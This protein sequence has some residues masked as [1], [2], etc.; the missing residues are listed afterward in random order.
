MDGIIMNQFQRYVIRTF[1]REAWTNLLEAANLPLSDE[2]L[3]VG[4]IYP[5][6]DLLALLTAAVDLTGRSLPDLLEDFGFYI[7][8]TLIR[9]YQALI[10]PGWG[11]L[12]LI[13]HTEQSIH[14]V[15]RQR[16]PGAAP[17]AL[18][19]QRY[20]RAVVAV[21]YRSQRR[22]CDLARGIIRGIAENFHETVRIA[23][24]EC[25]LRGD[26]RCLILVHDETPG[27]ASDA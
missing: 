1:G 14:T 23:Q 13:E 24:P 18:T 8:P 4:K 20:S 7:A 25:M 6:S 12:D 3:A 10:Q 2:L 11:A 15:V 27:R 19:T 26:A 9:V 5:D 17:P 16:N 21:D 22:L